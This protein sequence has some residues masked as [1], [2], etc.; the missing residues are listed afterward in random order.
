MI[1]FKQ[2]ELIETLEQEIKS[3]FPAFKI[4]SISD[5]VDNGLWI[6]IRELNDEESELEL[7]ELIA[8]KVTDILVTHGYHFQVIPTKAY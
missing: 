7:E 1:S 4:L 5:N 6:T 8:E 2:K 3:R